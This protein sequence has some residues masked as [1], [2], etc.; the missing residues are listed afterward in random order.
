MGWLVDF[1]MSGDMSGIR[2]RKDAVQQIPTPFL[3]Y[4]RLLC[5]RGYGRCKSRRVFDCSCGLLCG[6]N[7]R[8]TRR[9]LEE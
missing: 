6:D 2:G 7:L 3:L 5:S 4:R 9:W 8:E 1:S